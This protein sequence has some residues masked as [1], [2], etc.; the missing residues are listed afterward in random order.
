MATAAAISTPT[1][2]ALSVP[3]TASTVDGVAARSRPGPHAGQDRPRASRGP[4]ARSSPAAAGNEYHSTAAS[5]A[6]AA[7]IHAAATNCAAPTPHAAGTGGSSA[8]SGAAPPPHAAGTG[9][10]SAGSGPAG[11]N[12]TS[13]GW[14]FGPA[15]GPR[16]ASQAQ[17][18]VHSPCTTRRTARSACS[19]P[20]ATSSPPALAH[21]PAATAVPRRDDG[22]SSAPIA[23]P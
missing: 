3:T 12:S 20:I 15:E 2:R 13:S 19:R 18:R 23:A 7:P 6:V 17:P 11:P 22:S 8:R 1:A 9:G 4:A 5:P 16:P 10:S 14:V 21:T